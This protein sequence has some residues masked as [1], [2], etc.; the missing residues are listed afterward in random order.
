MQTVPVRPFGRDDDSVMAE[1]LAR[2]D[3]ESAARMLRRVG[4]IPVNSTAQD[5]QFMRSQYGVLEAI[6]ITVDDDRFLVSWISDEWEY[7]DIIISWMQWMCFLA[8]VK[9]GCYSGKNAVKNC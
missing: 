1:L 5:Y 8:M 3:I 4:C 7:E 6:T 2:L 9:R